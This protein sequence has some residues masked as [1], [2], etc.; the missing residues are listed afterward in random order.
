MINKFCKQP[1]WKCHGTLVKVA[2]GQ[3]P[4]DV[5]IRHTTLVCVTTRELLSDVDIAISCGRIAYL[6]IDG[7]TAEHC[8]G[9]STTIIDATGLY[10]APGFMDSHIHIESSM[11]APSEYAR[12]V[13]PHGTT[14]IMWDPHE[15]AN[16]SG[17]TAV[18]VAVRDAQRTPLKAMVTTPS[19]VPA[20]PGFEDTGSSV[21]AADVKE[22]M[23]WDSVVG[24]GE[25]MNYPGIL[26]CEDNAMDE[27]AETLKADRE[28]TGHYTVPEH[29][30]D[31]NAYIAAG[32]TADHESFRP[33][34]V[35]AKLRLGM[36]VQLRQGSAWQNMKRLAPAITH[37]QIDSRFCTLCS[38][39]NQPR[40][41]VADGHVD[42]LLRLAVSC[43][44]NPIEAVQMA[45]INCATCF[46]LEHELGSIAPGKCA[47]IVLLDS[48]DDFSVRKVFI[49]GDLVAENGH[50]L[51]DV[52]PFAWPSNLT[53]TMNLGLKICPETFRI[54]TNKPDGSCRVRVIGAE[55][56][57]TITKDLVMSAPVKDGEILADPT[58]DLIKVFVF[59]RHHG[60]GSHAAG[61]LHGFRIHGALAQTV[62]HDAH[63]LL[64]AGDNDQDM[65][66]A[67][68]T[69]ADCGGG[70]VAVQDGK[71]LALVELPICGLLSQGRIEDVAEN[72]GQ[73]EAAWKQMGC[74]MPSPFMTMGIM[75]LACVPVLRITNKGYVNCDTYQFE[76]LEVD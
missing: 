29:D 63:N 72:V 65:A 31:L 73:M 40:T 2:R 49:D 17:L 36:Y 55:A 47:D 64:V 62:A 48:L 34:D 23:N 76:P 11:V 15:I 43:G 50:A 58:Q 22:S 24:L 42:R 46:H 30:R 19:C 52:K 53:H 54:L 38:D 32:V 56:G 12:A 18:K 41:I 28:V 39:D 69:L 3:E 44:I 5:V 10:A 61:F 20:V 71:I 35:V 60:T 57:S 21:T 13:V 14:A 16:V 74:A 9:P 37:R 68:R 1:L 67:A 8:I 4:A 45:T 33:E 70:E 59:E 27:V 25:M 51:F 66:L 6:G 75:S 26:A 7:N